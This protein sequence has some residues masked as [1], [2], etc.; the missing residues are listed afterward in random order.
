MIV[1]GAVGAAVLVANVV[2]DVVILYSVSPGVGAGRSPLRFINGGDYAAAS[3]EGFISVAYSTSQQVGFTAS[4]KA[5]DGEYG[6]YLLDMVEV[7]GLT[8]TSTTWHLHLD[9][10]GALVG[11]GI[12]AAWVFDCTLSPSG[13]PDTGVPLASGT[14]SSGDPWAIYAPTC[15]GTQGSL[16]LG[17]LGTGT[18]IA[19]PN[20]VFGRSV[21]FLSFAVAVSSAGASTSTP[22]TLVLSATSP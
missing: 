10:T 1:L 14:D 13:V 15:P 9:V 22:A 8:N 20:L 7:E 12:N 17:A 19:L 16:S 2:G 4:V 5:A 3:A 11:V 18:T 6:T 21:L